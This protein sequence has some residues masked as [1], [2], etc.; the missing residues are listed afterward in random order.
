MGT[1]RARK[2]SHRTQ[3]FGQGECQRLV[4]EAL[5]DAVEPLSCSALTQTLMVRKGLA[6]HQEVETAVSKTA[7]AVLRRMVAKGVVRRR[8]LTEGT[9]VWALLGR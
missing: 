4:L 6:M 3:W 8:T 5:R 2:R 1:I 9:L 7:L